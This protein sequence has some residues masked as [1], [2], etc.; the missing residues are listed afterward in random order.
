MKYKLKYIF[1]IILPSFFF[2]QGGG[3]IPQF[4]PW[5]VWNKYPVSENDMI[6]EF[7]TG[8][9]YEFPFGLYIVKHCNEAIAGDYIFPAF[10]IPGEYTEIEKY[11]P[12]QDG[13]IFYLIGDGFKRSSEKTEFQDNTRLQVKMHI[14][15]FDECYFEYVSREDENG[16]HLSY[17]PEENVTYKRLRVK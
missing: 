3:H 14:R 9:Y 11:M 15:N 13:F 2:F 10:A 7:S 17:F 6:R 1:I 12:I 8:K 16:F 4:D 5:G